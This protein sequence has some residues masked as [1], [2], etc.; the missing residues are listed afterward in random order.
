[1]QPSTKSNGRRTSHCKLGEREA[2]EMRCGGV[3]PRL[4]L[5]RG[6]MVFD[7]GLV[8]KRM[9]KPTKGAVAFYVLPLCD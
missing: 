3:V 9:L 8:D 6:L 7:F 2:S 4:A 5:R 1:M